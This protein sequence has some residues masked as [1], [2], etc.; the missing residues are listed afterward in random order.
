LDGLFGFNVFTEY[1]PPNKKLWIYIP[2]G[3]GI[4]NTGGEK[5]SWVKGV[6]SLVL[7]LVEDLAV[8]VVFPAP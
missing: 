5:G 8:S 7:R 2:G 1:Y 3:T 6:I 4:L